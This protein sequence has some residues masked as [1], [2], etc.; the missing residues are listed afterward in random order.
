MTWNESAI[1]SLAAAAFFIGLLLGRIIWGGG[2]ATRDRLVADRNAARATLADRDA[3]VAQH[4]RD[5]A[6]ARDQIK[7]LADEVDRLR[8][9]NARLLARA[10]VVVAAAAAPS[11]IV[12][13][14][15][16]GVAPSSH[17]PRADLDDLRL[18]KGVGDKLV[19]RLHELGLSGNA[20]LAALSAADAEGLDAKLG[21]FAGRIA[22]DRLQDQARLLCEGRVTEFEAR[23]GK[24]ER[25]VI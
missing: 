24:L 8:C 11:A 20:E 2:G 7:P 3:A 17:A 25:P 10:P 1:L 12:G 5:L 4:A 14:A 23:Y 15:P 21:P 22:R 16:L 18:L 19:A 9:E 6:A 13:T